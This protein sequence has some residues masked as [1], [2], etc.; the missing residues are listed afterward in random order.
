MDRRLDRRLA[1]QAAGKRPVS[2]SILGEH[3]TYDL[4]TTTTGEPGLYI[5]CWAHDPVQYSDFLVQVA[6]GTGGLRRGRD[7]LELTFPQ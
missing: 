1:P 5:V 3:A 7:L 4:G 2:T 6:R